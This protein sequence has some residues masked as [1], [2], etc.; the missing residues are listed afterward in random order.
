MVQ[1]DQAPI[2]PMAIAGM[3]ELFDNPTKPFFTETVED[4]LFNG[5]AINC[6]RS[7]FQAQSICSALEDTLGETAV[8]NETHLAMSLF[9][10]VGIFSLICSYFY[11]IKFHCGF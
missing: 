8:V 2:L 6:D 1:R 5:V 11:K 10:A 4:L 3:L 9:K 7:G